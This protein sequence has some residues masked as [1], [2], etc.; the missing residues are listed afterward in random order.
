MER[1]KSDLKK[2]ALVMGPPPPQ[3][4]GEK[5]KDTGGGSD[6]EAMAIGSIDAGMGAVGGF[7]GKELGFSKGSGV[8]VSKEID[9]VSHEVD[10][11]VGLGVCLAQ[12]ECTVLIAEPEKES[13]AKKIS[14][15][16]AVCDDLDEAVKPVFVVKDGIADVSIPEDLM[17]DVD[18]LWKCFVVGYFM[19]DAPHIGIIHSTVNRIWASP[20]KGSKIDV[21]FIGKRTVLF[22]VEDAQEVISGSS[23]AVVTELLTE[24]ENLSVKATLDG[25]VSNT[26]KDLRLFLNNLSSSTESEK[27]VTLGDQDHRQTSPP[28]EKQ[29]P[30]EVTS[31]NSFELL[32]YIREEGEIDE[33]EELLGEE[34]PKLQNEEGVD[35]LDEGTNGD[36]KVGRQ[37]TGQGAGQRGKGRWRALFANSRGLVNAVVNSQRCLVE[38]SVQEESFQQ[39][40]SDTFP[41]WH[42]LHNYSHHRLD[43]ASHGQ[44]SDDKVAGKVK[45]AKA[46]YE[47]LCEKQNNALQNPLT[48]NFEEASDAWENWH[49]LSGIEEQLF[50]QKSRV[51]W[52]G[53]GDRNINFYMKTCQTRNSRNTIRRLV[54]S[55]GRV[56]TELTDIKVEAVAYYEGGK[57]ALEAA[58]A[59]RSLPVSALPIKYLGL[60]LTTKTMSR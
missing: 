41:G 34:A 2:F 36:D 33:D 15:S 60:P 18:P 27:W 46:A 29:A 59:T 11:S 1:D 22:R 19:N 28:R 16:N 10:S 6:G 47:E 8:G 58:A 38:T 40:F 14:Y 52:L 25:D 51:K 55:D 31:P 48:S 30:V 57:Q 3:A 42:Y 4:E 13:F 17:E 39:V 20:G 49:H 23:R 7:D 37:K 32:Q 43:C 56:L 35:V 44:C 24:L 54:A 9:L 12:A 45:E 50:Y 26:W 5:R 53:L 21:Q